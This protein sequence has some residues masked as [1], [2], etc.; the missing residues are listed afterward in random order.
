MPLRKSQKTVHLKSLGNVFEYCVLHLSDK[1]LLTIKNSI[2][3]RILKHGRNWVKCFI[4]ILQQPSEC[5]GPF[6]Q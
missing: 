6:N 3:V 2:L 5:S 1:L 4:Y